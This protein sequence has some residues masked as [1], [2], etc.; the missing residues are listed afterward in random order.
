[1]LIFSSVARVVP[2]ALCFGGDLWLSG[3]VGFT[4]C[5]ILF[6]GLKTTYNAEKNLCAQ[7]GEEPH[8]ITLPGAGQVAAAAAG[9][10]FCVAS[11]AEP[12]LA[13][14]PH[15]GNLELETRGDWY[16]S[17]LLLVLPSQHWCWWQPRGHHDHH[18]PG[19]ATGHP[20][21]GWPP[22]GPAQP[23]PGAPRECAPSVQHADGG[24]GP[25]G[26]RAGQLGK[27]HILF[28]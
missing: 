6:A 20:I 25:P 24:C 13:A 16:L 4:P 12:P 17:F 14:F 2:M 22:G 15:A 18:K 9:T 8:A 5:K 28:S 7:S 19:A 26:R 3:W 21:P 10:I 1:M 23:G 11:T 27:Q